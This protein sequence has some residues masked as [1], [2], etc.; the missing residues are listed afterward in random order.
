MTKNE[1]KRYA[2]QFMARR[3]S[4]IVSA[5]NGFNDVMA[6]FADP[7]EHDTLE[8]VT[9]DNGVPD[10]T[11]RTNSVADNVCVVRKADLIIKIGHL[12]YFSNSK[13]FLRPPID[14]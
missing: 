11:T 6:Q 3:T 8:D 10:T 2:E 14:L 5:Q 9:I 13:S 4:R 12:A 7:Y 1:Q